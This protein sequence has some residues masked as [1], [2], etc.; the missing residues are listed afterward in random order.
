[1]AEEIR[2]SRELVEEAPGPGKCVSRAQA[3]VGEGLKRIETRRRTEGRI[4]LQ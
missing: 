3:Y 1:M 4:L 2:I